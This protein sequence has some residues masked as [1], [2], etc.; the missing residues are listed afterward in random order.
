MLICFV[1]AQ[2]SGGLGLVANDGA[3]V[4][5]RAVFFGALV[6]RASCLTSLFLL[7]LIAVTRHVTCVLDGSV[8]V[9][10][11][12]E[13]SQFGLWA[14]SSD[15]HADVWEQVEAMSKSELT[16]IEE[17]SVTSLLAVPLIG[18]IGS[19]RPNR[20]NETSTPSGSCYGRGYTLVCTT[21]STPPGQNALYFTHKVGRTHISLSQ[22]RN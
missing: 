1:A 17:V 18:H 10:V 6:A 16:A 8:I 14:S 7:A 2:V 3:V 5:D 9:G 15:V 12:D 22:S 13:V 4:V 19:A 21:A 20:G 11:L